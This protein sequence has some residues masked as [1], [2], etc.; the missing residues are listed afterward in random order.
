MLL[1]VLNASVT[2]GINNGSSHYWENYITVVIN[3]TRA[4]ITNVTNALTT[5]RLSAINPAGLGCLLAD[6]SA[7]QV[8][9]V[10]K[11]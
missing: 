9:H 5:Y 2:Y 3:L 4:R 11:Q 6:L 8:F 7:L 10:D 1:F